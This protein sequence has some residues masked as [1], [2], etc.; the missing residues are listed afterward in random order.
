MFADEKNTSDRRTLADWQRGLRD[1][2]VSP[3][4]TKAGVRYKRVNAHGSENVGIR[5][6]I[7]ETKFGRSYANEIIRRV[8]K[9]SPGTYYVPHP[10]RGAV[11]LPPFTDPSMSIPQL[12][13]E[14]QEGKA[15]NCLVEVKPTRPIKTYR[16]E[17]LTDAQAR[18]AASVYRRSSIKCGGIASYNNTKLFQYRAD[19]SV[20]TIPAWSADVYFCPQGTASAMS[21]ADRIKVQLVKDWPNYPKPFPN[22]VIT[23]WRSAN[24]WAAK[25][26]CQTLT[27]RNA[28]TGQPQNFL[29]CPEA[30]PAPPVPGEPPPPFPGPG[31]APGAPP[32]TAPFPTGPAPRPDVT[33]AGMAG[34]LGKGALFLGGGLLL[35]SLLSR[36]S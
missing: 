25:N 5:V 3:S 14:L 17:D 11:K 35:Y 34:T 4:F 13:S 32:G 21:V 22:E 16:Y 1:G 24:A 31:P 10:T 12:D 20:E 9:M 30:P 18:I 36:K 33:Q 26:R 29:N 7:P 15:V 27:C 2:S 23:N 6:E 8:S 28:N 19:G